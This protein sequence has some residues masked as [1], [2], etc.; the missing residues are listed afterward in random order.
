MKSGTSP[1]VEQALLFRTR[2]GKRVRTLGTVVCALAA[3]SLGSVPNAVALDAQSKQWY[4]EPMKAE[5]M[6]KTST[7]KGIKV[8]VIGTGVNPKTPSLRGQVLQGVDALVKDG[9]AEGSVTDTDDTTGVGTTA[10]ELIAGTGTGGGLKGL[11]P[12]AEIVPIRVPAIKHDTL[13]DPNYP[14]ATAIKAAVDS[15]A[16]II[17]ITVG[18]Q[19]TIGT[20][21][22]GDEALDYAVKKGVLMFA[23]A[24]DNAKKGN[25]RQYP[26]A[27]HQVVGVGATD[28]TAKVT[29]T[30]NSAGDAD[31]AAPGMGFPRWCDASF[32]QYCND[33]VGTA[34]A[35]ALTSAA[36]ALIWSAHPDWTGNQV[37]RSLIDTAGRTYPKDEPSRYI[38]YGVI[39]PRNVLENANYNAG[40]ADVDPLSVESRK[41]AASTASPSVSAPAASQAPEKTATGGTSAAGSSTES[42]NDSITLWIALGAFAAVVVVGGAG[43]A[44]IRARRAR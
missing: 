32:Q 28:E 14:L 12:A 39:R 29:P 17:D 43:A 18:N 40:P 4:L 25:K 37:V 6:W 13:P 38:G 34:E 19:Y 42:S 21:L 30:S 36:A 20:Q 10:A 35:S 41:K 16:R 3:V 1:R 9:L 5:Q 8:A 11:A 33:G 31:L 23:A 2:F 44:I 7:G 24:G 26:A 22:V 27:Y 15:G